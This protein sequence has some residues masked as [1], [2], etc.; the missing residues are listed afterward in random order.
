MQRCRIIQ[1]TAADRQ[2]PHTQLHAITVLFVELSGIGS[3]MRQWKS[4]LVAILAVEALAV[5]LPVVA[6]NRLT[7]ILRLSQARTFVETERPATRGHDR[8][9]IS[10]GEA[11]PD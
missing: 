10:A 2:V 3:E 6:K 1:L 11:W 8:S 7:E 5:R 9:S 4:L